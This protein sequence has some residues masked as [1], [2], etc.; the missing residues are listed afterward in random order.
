MKKKC[1]STLLLSLMSLPII[2]QDI[3]VKK[4]GPL[5][6]DQTAVT[7]ARKDIN[8]N[9]CGLV[10]VALKEAGAE[11]EGN[12][13][14]DVQFTGSEY[15]VYLPNGT[16]RLGIK[17]P[18]FLPTTIVFADYGTKRVSSGTTYQLNV[19][20]NKKKAKVDNS[21][22]GM[23][24]FNIK[25]SNAMLMIDGQIADGSGG[26]Y[27]LSLPYG[28]HYYTVKLKDF[29]LNNQAVHVDKNA[30]TVNVDLTEFFAK[31]DVSCKT[32]DAEISVNGEQKGIGK[33]D[34]LV[35]PGR[36][37]F[38]AKKEGYHTISKTIDLMDDEMITVNLPEMKAI[39]GTLRVENVL[40]NCEVLLNGKKVGITPW[41]KKDLPVGD[42]NV[43]IRHKY[44]R[45]I[46]KSIHIS[47]GQD[48]LMN[49]E[50]VPTSLGRLYQKAENGNTRAQRMLADLY[51]FGVEE[52]ERFEKEYT[53]TAWN[54]DCIEDNSWEIK[55]Q[56]LK[57]EAEEIK[58]DVT[59]ELRWAKKLASE[60]LD[61]CA[62]SWLN[63]ESYH[64]MECF[65]IGD[66]FKQDF[67]QSLYWAK[68]A[69][70]DDWWQSRVWVAWHYYYGRGVGKD[71]N[72]ALLWLNKGENSSGKKYNVCTNE[73][74]K[75]ELIND[76]AEWM[77]KDILR[78]LN[79]D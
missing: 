37:V 74:L 48:F 52:I 70:E 36:C 49:E 47:E 14:G 26:A 27:T 21:K 61:Y 62:R 6:K 33:W 9:T 13:M 44:Y 67:S 56:D 5:E 19:K 10:K 60:K 23:A 25:P 43:E 7:S 11:F 38:E 24:V 18:D 4:F 30:K 35:A 75:K 22:K 31:V 64:L 20:T 15:L 32:E 53:A 28:T 77:N 39:T 58:K 40:D 45:P 12:V 73:I 2:A 71:I 1:F 42:Y 17:H 34:G 72:Q 57:G 8:G 68:V 55:I 65:L 41:G 54:D 66:G 63:L 76:Q 46:N 59:E 50:L 78:L 3:E 29:S 51:R 69:A 79:N 16:K